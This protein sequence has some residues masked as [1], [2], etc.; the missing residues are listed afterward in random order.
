MEE[1][2]EAAPKKILTYICTGCD[3]GDSLDVEKLSGVA[4]GMNVEVKTHD[5]LCGEDGLAIIIKDIAGGVNTVVIA[6]C[7]Q[8]A[9]TDVFDFDPLKVVTERINLREG[10]VWVTEPNN[11]DTQA[12]ADD[13]MKMGLVKAQK[14][15]VPEPFSEEMSKT[16][17]VVGG[18]PT[19]IT[20]ALEA[21]RAGSDVVLVEKEAELG[22][23]A[24]KV[25]K[26]WSPMAPHEELVDPPIDSFIQAV[27]EAS[28][29]KVYK[30]AKIE[31]IAGAPGMFDV[32]IKQNGSSASEKIGAIVLATGF[33]PYDATKLSHLGYG[34]KNV[35]TNFEFEEMAKN[36]ELASKP[37]K[38]IVFVQ[39]AGSRDPEHLPYCSTVCCM[40]SLKQAKYVRDADQNA[41]TYIIYKDMRTPGQYEN[42]YKM[43]QDDDGVFMTKGEVTGVSEEGDGLVVGASDTLLGGNIKIKAEMVVLATGMVPATA[44]EDEA[45][46]KA[47]ET[48]LAR[49]NEEAPQAAK[50]DDSEPE[51]ER[52]IPSST[53]NLDYMQGPEVPELGNGYGFPD[54]HYICFPYETRRTGIYAAGPVRAPMDSISAAA[55]AAGAALKAIQCVELTSKGRAVHPRSGDMTYPDLYT[56]RCTQ[57]KRCTQECPFGMYNEDEKAS[58]LPNPT[59]CRRCGICMGSCPERI[60][61]FK[62][63][64]I[65]IVGSMGKAISAPEGKFRIVVFACENDALPALD[66]AGLNR[67]KYSASVRVIPLRCAG[68]LNLVWVADILS[69]GADGI[70]ILG[71]KHGDDY[72]CHFIK[73]SE[74]C[75]YRLG[76]VQE[77]LSRL[78]LEAERVQFKP[79]AIEDYDRVSEIIDGFVKRV[80]EIGPNPFKGM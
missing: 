56:Q 9:K 7:S 66:M 65:D 46:V 8:R 48:A 20:A 57:C 1:Q 58:P 26:T 32:S 24:K 31:K 19:G 15:D 33:V 53:L 72:Q 28:N 42:F 73:G 71:C 23:Y 59:R 10:V 39:C 21:S 47:W 69:A 35:V 64:S 40:T 80:E 25:H 63:F 38:S 34:L 55:D 60:I 62:N 78:M 22:G 49:G 61:S 29:I 27:E 17:L 6:A 79:L 2:Q 5:N 11:E 16:I 51:D 18:G 30:G 77:T 4:T 13:Y 52:M 37:P 75:E 14:S 43:V 74:L 44:V 12:M 76:K 67:N 41:N 68:N 45:A 36:G 3:I 54:S 50:K 70:L